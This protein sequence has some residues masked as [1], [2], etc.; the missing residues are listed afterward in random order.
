M[1]RMKWRLPQRRLQALYPIQMSRI[2]L[3]LEDIDGIVEDLVLLE[4]TV[5]GLPVGDTPDYSSPL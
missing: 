3:Q 5:N 2:W 1:N 4:A